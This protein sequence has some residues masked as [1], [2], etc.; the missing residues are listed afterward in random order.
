MSY[1]A[2][3]GLVYIP[4]YD[5]V[6]EPDGNVAR[7]AG[8]LIAWDPVK[9]AARWS[10]T[11]SLAINSGVLSTAGNLV[12]AGEGTGEFSAY[13]ADSGH[14]LWSV[15][16]G[17]AIDSVPVSFTAN[18]EQYVIIPVGLGSGSRLFEPVSEMATPEAKLGPARL[19]AFK[20]GAAT[21]FP[22]PKVVVPS[23]PRPPN[24]TASA[25]TIKHGA[26]V[27]DD[28]MCSDCHSPEADGSGAWVVNG[29]VPDLRYMPKDVHD[30]F[31]A[32]VLGGSHKANG[33]PGFSS[34]N[35]FPLERTNMSAEDAIAVHSYIIELSWKAYNAQQAKLRAGDAPP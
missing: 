26:Q 4:A 1:S 31:L 7:T 28:F 25:E 27:F 19:L 21:P 6:V 11:E 8:R 14:K 33:M 17:S 29:A 35:D 18:N 24:Q 10:A 30:Q 22:Y 9:Q 34:H 13:A 5:G 3:A 20:L 12:F 32:I 2:A 16:T 23:V 15:K